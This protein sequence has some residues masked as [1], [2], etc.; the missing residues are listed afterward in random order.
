MTDAD[1]RI[2]QFTEQMAALGLPTSRPHRERWF[3]RLGLGAM[4]LGIVIAIVGYL[5][6]LGVEAT[7]GSNVDLLNTGSHII[8]ALIGVAV[9]IAGAVVYLRYSLARF[10]RYWLARQLIARSPDNEPR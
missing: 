1:D 8:T 5:A 3:E 6:S 9:S 7:P 4:A 10:L 2:R